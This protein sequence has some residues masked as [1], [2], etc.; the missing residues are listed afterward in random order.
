MGALM[1]LKARPGRFTLFPPVF[2][3]SRSSF[4]L[5]DFASF[6]LEGKCR[7]LSCHSEIAFSILLA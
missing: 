1:V 3:H 7:T 2:C 5:D 6:L 4:P